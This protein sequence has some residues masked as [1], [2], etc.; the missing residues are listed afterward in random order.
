MG[1]AN[2]S[3]TF[4][5]IRRDLS[6]FSGM[7]NM[8]MLGLMD[9]TC[10]IAPPDETTSKRVRTT[11]S[12]ISLAGLPSKVI[13]YAVADSLA[14]MKREC[15][16]LGSEAVPT[17][18]TILSSEKEAT[19]AA[20]LSSQA[21]V[22]DLD[23][24]ISVWD[25]VL[26]TFRGRDNEALFGM[27]DGRGTL[28]GSRI[29][30]HLYELFGTYFE[31]ELAREE[32]ELLARTETFAGNTMEKIQGIG[33]STNSLNTNKRGN[34]RQHQSKGGA[35]VT[36]VDVSDDSQSDLLELLLEP[37]SIE[38][39]LRR[40]FL[41]A[42]KVIGSLYAT[43]L[44]ITPPPK[45]D[46]GPE[47]L[48]KPTHGPLLTLQRN[49]SSTPQEP[50]PTP[51]P[52]SPV[53]QMNPAGQP[54]FGSSATVVYLVG[55][56]N[57]GKSGK[58]TMYVANIGDGMAVLSKGGGA[59]Q[60]LSCNHNIGLDILTASAHTSIPSNRESVL[61]G[62]LDITK[63]YPPS[64]EPG[65]NRSGSSW[66]WSEVE[67]IREAG[68]WVSSHG[69]INGVLDISRG[70]GY[71]P[72]LGPV[73]AHPHI[74]KVELELSPPPPPKSGK[75][76]ASPRD[77]GVED[78]TSPTNPDDEFIVLAS[79]AVWKTLK[80]GGSYEDG[81]HNLVNVA[82]SAYGAS[83]LSPTSGASGSPASITGTIT[84]F[85]GYGSP[86]SYTTSHNRLMLGSDGAQRQG[87]A[88]GGWCSAA[89]KIRDIAIGLSGPDA[90][91][92]NGLS[93]MLLGLRDLAIKSTWWNAANGR[94]GST[95]DNLQRSYDDR[96]K[97]QPSKTAMEEVVVNV[98]NSPC[99]IFVN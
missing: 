21:E 46:A 51:V 76:K 41:L 66:P 44:P 86:T 83:L 37:S 63:H 87:Q 30:Q 24:A 25:L 65:I 6:D 7:T 23:E 8:H 70:F 42:N 61:M 94:R 68:G 20:N 91:S 60:I 18:P 72:C 15:E 55:S 54:L 26:P 62:P 79:G 73:M 12:E 84:S 31:Q 59:S 17:S 58:C 49:Q 74:Q 28:G 45:S 93:V 2:D 57:A 39:A 75:P 4:N 29:A 81:A 43:F 99:F 78:I 19:A 82:R 33:I 32:R 53:A 96:F 47:P 40:A 35:G 27:F 3:E 14:K 9:V 90:E 13:R 11:G 98:S 34:G 92:S 97:K 22:K 69:L 67:R 1:S 36:S 5:E 89:T 16:F 52:K 88:L 77:P 71:V 56:R 38:N 48:K 95:G 10:L 64:Q 50:P 85:G 80:M